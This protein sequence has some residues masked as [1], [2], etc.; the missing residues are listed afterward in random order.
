MLSSVLDCSKQR[1][2][3]IPQP[4]PR[5]QERMFELDGGI[6]NAPRFFDQMTRSSTIHTNM[7]KPLARVKIL[8]SLAGGFKI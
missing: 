4:P 8:K 1:V 6:E 3:V 7:D 2:V 5:L